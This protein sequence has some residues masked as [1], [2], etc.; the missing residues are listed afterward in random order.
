MLIEGDSA[1]SSSFC[2]APGGE[3]HAVLRGKLLCSVWEA[4]GR[5]RWHVGRTGGDSEACQFEVR[6]ALASGGRQRPGGLGDFRF[7]WLLQAVGQ[8]LLR[9]S[10]EARPNASLTGG[11]FVGLLFE[12]SSPALPCKPSLPR[13]A[14]HW[15]VCI[16]LRHRQQTIREQQTSVNG[17]MQRARHEDAGDCAGKVNTGTSQQSLGPGANGVCGGTSNV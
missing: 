13:L 4:L 8:G 5:A 6:H 2:Q 3:G 12:K 10:Q 16:V 1:V 11:E 9:H 17:V 7:P 14:S 15:L